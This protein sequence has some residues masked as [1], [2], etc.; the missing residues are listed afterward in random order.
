MSVRRRM[1]DLFRSPVFFGQTRQF[2]AIDDHKR[3]LSFFTSSP[4]RT[5]RRKAGQREVSEQHPL[6]SFICV[7]AVVY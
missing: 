6:L 4:A 5:G 7:K 1:G 2:I 3:L